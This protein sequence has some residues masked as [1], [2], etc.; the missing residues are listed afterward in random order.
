MAHGSDVATELLR[1]GRYQEARDLSARAVAIDPRLTR[2]HSNL[3]WAHIF[4][5]DF[6]QGIASLEHAVALSPES[7]LF[8]AQL[9]EAFAMA[10]R[11]D[12]ARD[13]LRKLHALAKERHVSPYHFAYVY[14]GLGENDAAIDWLEKAY[15][16]REGAIYG[17][18]GSF[19][20][21]GL[22]SHPRFQAL[23]RKM[24]LG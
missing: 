7:T 15:D 4:L 3:G 23:L 5:G 9:G 12:E 18:K 21:T 11:L 13:I 14:A 10:G 17:I 20:F 24:N 1:S 6:E 16:Q 22:R 8:Q 19:L 2:G